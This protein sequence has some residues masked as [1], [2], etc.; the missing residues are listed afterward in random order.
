MRPTREYRRG[1]NRTSGPQAPLRGAT[2]RRAI[3]SGIIAL[4]TA[5]LALVISDNT[6]IPNA[7]RYLI[8]PGLLVGFRVAKL[9]PCGGI[10]DCM[11]ALAGQLGQML[12]ITLAVNLVLYGLLFFGI[13]T[14]ISA[15]KPERLDTM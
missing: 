15:L 12:K 14:A 10:L 5:I 9:Q 3:W 8:S 1:I 13:A 4:P 2:W 7:L 11:V 6:S